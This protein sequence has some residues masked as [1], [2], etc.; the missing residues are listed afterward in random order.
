M[1]SYVDPD[2]GR[3]YTN[4][5]DLSKVTTE[6]LESNM[7]NLDNAVAVNIEILNHETGE[8]TRAYINELKAK[9]WDDYIYLDKT[10]VSAIKKFVQIYDNGEI[11][12]G[13]LKLKVYIQNA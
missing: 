8:T 11:Y 7:N 9:T 5:I 1:I 4:M 2:T 12:Q 6:H 13:T 10:D 3:V